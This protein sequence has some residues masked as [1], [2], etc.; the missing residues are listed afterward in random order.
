MSTTNLFSGTND[1]LERMTPGRWL[2]YSVGWDRVDHHGHSLGRWALYGGDIVYSV[3]G[4]ISEV[5][6]EPDVT[7]AAQVQRLPVP[8]RRSPKCGL[9][10]RPE[11]PRG[12]FNSCPRGGSYQVSLRL[13]THHSLGKTQRPLRRSHFGA[14]IATGALR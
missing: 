7:P 1:R 8:E 13:G 4:P 2:L 9:T 10:L 3:P 11:P 5:P 12:N 6:N 14:S